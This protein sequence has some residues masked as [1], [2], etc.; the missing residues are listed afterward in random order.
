MKTF[1]R[2]SIIVIGLVNVVLFAFWLSVIRIDVL[3][4]ERLALAYHFDALTLQI[5]M[6][7]VF[8]VF[9]AIALAVAGFF[10][11]QALAERAETTANRTAIEVV[12]E[13]HK[14]GQLG[15]WPKEKGGTGIQPGSVPGV[16]AVNVG[17]A[18]PEAENT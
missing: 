5:A 11:F 3:T 18:L 13:L 8:G 1:L 7:E 15:G 2:A 6:L 16:A 10:G 4:P 12:H 17:G 14:H 9:F